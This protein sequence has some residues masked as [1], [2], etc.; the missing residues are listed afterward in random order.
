MD[1]SF[2]FLKEKIL[3]NKEKI[4]AS[5]PA[6]YPNWNKLCFFRSPFSLP[7]TARW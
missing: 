3:A 4:L 1:Q 6:F 2:S 5:G 7:K